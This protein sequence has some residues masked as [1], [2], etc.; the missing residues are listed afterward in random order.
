MVL[1]ES[2]NVQ[3]KMIALSTKKFLYISHLHTYSIIYLCTTNM[4]HGIPDT[5]Q[6]I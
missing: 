4:N 6:N 2:E 1:L 5:N 3:R